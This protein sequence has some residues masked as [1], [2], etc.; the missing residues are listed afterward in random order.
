MAVKKYLDD[1]G[2]KTLVHEIKKSQTS[3]YRVKGSAVYADADY[4]AHASA[5]DAGYHSGINAVGLWQLVSNTWTQT[6]EFEVG[7][8]YNIENTFTTDADFVEGAGSVVAAGS[9]I[10]VAEAEDNAG[11]TTYKWDQLGNVLDMTAYQTK[12]L[13]SVLDTFTVASGTATEYVS[14]AALPSSE[15][16]ATATI[17]TYDVAILGGSGAAEADVGKC[18]RA[19]VTENA[20]DSTMNDIAWVQIGDQISVEGALEFLSK[21]CPNTPISDDEIKALFA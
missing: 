16:K 11:V 4:V 9:N 2:L 5:G 17:A 15:A 13:V 7:Y 21:I 19:V 14:E 10:V 12:K 3:V 8:V 1:H 20:T 6:N 18:F